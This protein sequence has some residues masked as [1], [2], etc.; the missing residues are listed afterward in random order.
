[1]YVTFT[2]Y[3][4]CYPDRPIHVAIL[5]TVMP[6]SNGP[7][8]HIQAYPIWSFAV[9]KLSSDLSVYHFYSSG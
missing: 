2:V 9:F 7:L 8:T 4:S 6:I 3:L 1:M 5:L